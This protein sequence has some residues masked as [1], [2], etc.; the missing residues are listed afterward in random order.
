MILKMI[1]VVLLACIIGG[2]FVDVTDIIELCANGK[3]VSKKNSK[4]K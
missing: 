1:I 3:I 2:I 4:R